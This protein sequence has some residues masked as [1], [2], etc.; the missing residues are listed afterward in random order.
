MH[1]PRSVLPIAASLSWP[2]SASCYAC[3]GLDAGSD[4]AR[5][6]LV[7]LRSELACHSQHAVVS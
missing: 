3:F 7:A 4:R 6:T 5:T 2:A 1:W